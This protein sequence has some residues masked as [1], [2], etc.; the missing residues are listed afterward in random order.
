MLKCLRAGHSL[1]TNQSSITQVDQSASFRSHSFFI[2]VRMIFYVKF[3]AIGNIVIKRFNGLI[4]ITGK[5]GTTAEAG[6][7]SISPIATFGKSAKPTSTKL[8]TP[9]KLIISFS[10][11]IW[12]LKS[13][14]SLTY[15]VIG[16]PCCRHIDRW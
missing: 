6:S 10:T 12:R 7:M 2:P 4:W 15:F 11:M 16:A 13:S 1:G 3:S 9:E 8:T 5:S 14:R